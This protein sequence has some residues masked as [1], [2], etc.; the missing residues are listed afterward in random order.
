MVGVHKAEMVQKIQTIM[1]GTMVE[2][3]VLV[4][5]PSIVEKAKDCMKTVSLIM[6][7]A[8]RKTKKHPTSLRLRIL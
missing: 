6:K 7:P 8:K 3:P 5:A 1:G 2:V 4:A